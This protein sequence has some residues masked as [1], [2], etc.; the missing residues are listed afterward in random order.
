LKVGNAAALRVPG[1]S[2][3][4]PARVSMVS[5]ALDAG[6]TTVEVWLKV[7]NQAGRLKVG[8]PVKALITG[9]TVTQ[10]LKVPASAI[11]TAD[12]GSK[13][14]MVIG[15][16]GAAHK[17]PVTLGLGNGSDVEVTGGLTASDLVITSGSYGLDEGT[18]VKIGAA[19]SDADSGGG[20]NH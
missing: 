1:L 6:S 10:A 3:P 18:R 4:V 9:R 17:K 7:E 14:V 11:L 8:T 5:P 16:D 2:A 19:A 20:G 15:A 12:D 13:S